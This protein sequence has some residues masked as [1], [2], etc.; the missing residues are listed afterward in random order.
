MAVGE[1]VRNLDWE[2]RTS[3]SARYTTDLDP[4][5][6]LHA[7][8]LRSPYARARIDRVDLRRARTAPGVA[9][10]MSAADLPDRTYQHLGG[11]FSDRRVFATGEVR[12]VGEEVAAVAAET[13][14]EADD[15]IE[16]IVVDY[17][18]RKAA[19]TTERALSAGAPLV[20]SGSDGNIALDISRAY[21][22]I[23]AAR[24]RATTTVSGSYRYPRAS[25][26]CMEPHSIVAQWDESE[27]RLDL[28][29][30]SQAPHFVRKEVA[31]VLDLDVDR[32]HTHEV[33]VG[34]GFGAKSKVGQHEA[35]AAALAIRTGRP[36]RLVLDRPEEF[37]TTHTR[38]EFR[39]DLTTGAT[40]EG[41]LTHRDCDMIVD[42]GAYNHNGPSVAVY[43]GML[44]AALHRVEAAESRARLV[45]TNSQAASSF[46]GFA[47]PQITFAME[48]QLD[49]L[50]DE[51]GLDPLD[52]RMINA[53]RDGD[54]TL[55]GWRLETARLAECLEAVGDAIGWDE[56]RATGG[57]GRGVGVATAVHPSGA[58]AYEGSEYSGVGVDVHPDGTVHVRFAGSDAGTGQAT[59]LAQIAATELGVDIDSVDVTMMASEGTPPDLGAWSSRGTMWSGHAVSTTARAAAGRL[60]DAAGEKLSVPPDA[61]DLR[62]GCAHAG[63]ESVDIGDLVLLIGDA[64]G[65]LRTEDG[66][67][68]DVDQMDRVT[69]VSNFS[70][71]YSFVA[72]AVEVEVDPDTGEVEVL[73]VVSAH[74]CGTAINPTAVEGQIVG[75]VAMGLGAALGEEM[76]HHEGRLVNPA[77]VDYAAPRA[78]DLPPIRPILVGGHDPKGPYGAKGVGEIGLVPTPA[79]VANAVAHA[80]GVRVRS[81]PITPDKLLPSIRDPIALRPLWR[82]PGRWWIEALR[83]AYPRGLL[84]V[85]DRRGT[86][87]ARPPRT[88]PIEEIVSPSTIADAVT[89]LG[90]DGAFIGGGTDLLARRSQGLGGAARLVDLTA[91]NGI[92]RI[93]KRDDGSLDI[94]ASVSLARLRTHSAMVGD[95]VLVEALDRL[96]TPQIREMATVAGNL[97]QAN[98]CWFYRNGFDCY[99]RSGPTCPCYAI[100]GDH[101]FHHAVLGGHRCQAVTPSD[102]ATVFP[103]LDAVVNVTGPQGDRTIAA[104]GLHSGPGESALDRDELIT[105]VTVPAAARSRQSAFEKLA[106]YGG[107]FAVVSA[108]VSVD[109]AAGRITDVRVFLGAVAPVPHRARRTEQ[110]LLGVE[111]ADLAAVEA[112]AEAW[113]VDAHPLEGNRWKVDAATGLLRRALRRVAANAVTEGRP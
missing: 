84:R 7:R 85:L 40:S 100:E 68:T 46:R 16:Q 97:L 8:I 1:R 101:R 12:F 87:W 13:L 90:D 45:Y 20:H 27:E 24:D 26:L 107:D 25:H 52:L 29:V 106:R 104:A 80:T 75:A 111:L 33:A 70:P 22:D 71:A 74:D 82:R 48:S 102:L 79:A 98:R 67:L 23:D 59:L 103:A 43:A 10:A 89:G 41:R 92:G 21:G 61:V 3:G 63:D 4:D 86:R 37:A 105:S 72:Q 108:A 18:R 73:Q 113:A 30:S 62:D 6:L 99:Q 56:K 77:F 14:A 109:H 53:H 32:V 78:S 17:H 65:V 110:N 57:A 94:G 55:T 58:R 44:T 88:S 15:A 96:A 11:S 9:A 112:A 19:A 42:N 50:A 66:Y 28:W 35:I 69:G 95:D 83:R 36:V 91:I 34:G 47:N 31:H 54:V 38:H 76:V 93:V 64:D 39:V 2:E 49:E 81:L 51:L 5:R 60:R